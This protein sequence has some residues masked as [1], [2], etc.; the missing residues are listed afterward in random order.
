ML[1]QRRAAAGRR[2]D[3]EDRDADTVVVADEL[4]GDPAEREV[5][6]AQ[7]GHRQSMPPVSNRSPDRVARGARA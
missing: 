4:V 7:C 1:V 6:D 5:V 3:E 2:L